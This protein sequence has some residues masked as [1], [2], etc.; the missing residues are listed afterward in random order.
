MINNK[1]H[2][3]N[4]FDEIKTYLKDTTKSHPQPGNR[5]DYNMYLSEQIDFVNENNISNDPIYLIQQFYIDKNQER[6]QEILKCLKL[7]VFNNSI[8]KIYLLNERIYD[9]NELGIQSE[10]IIQINIKE[11]LTYKDAF[12]F[13]ENNTI[14][15]N[16]HAFY[17][18]SNSD[19]FFNKSTLELK[20]MNIISNNRILALNRYD[21]KNEK[22]LTDCKL[23]DNGRPDS[24]DTWILHSSNNINSKFRDIFN[25]N[26]GKPG[27][28]NKICYL[29]NILNYKCYNEPTIIKTFHIHN[30]LSR[31]YTSVDKINKPYT[32]IFP[33]LDNF[34]ATNTNN[35]QTY[36]II[37]ENQ[38]FIK[39]LNNKITNNKQ[40]I[41]PK[42]GIN[43][44]KLAYLGILYNHN[45]KAF[46]NININ[47]NNLKIFSQ[48]Y[49]DAFHNSDIY[50]TW[51]PWS[52]KATHNNI[53]ESIVFI[54]DNFKTPTI[55]SE[56]LNVYN[57]I[58]SNNIWTQELKNKKILIIS[59][60]NN[61]IKNTI[62]NRNKIYNVELFPQCEFIFIDVPLLNNEKI[63]TLKNFNND[64]NSIVSNIKRE[65]DNF[66]IALVSCGIY[67]NLILSQISNINKSAINMD[68]S[69]QYLFGIY[70]STFENENKEISKLYKNEYWQKV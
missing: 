53:H 40:F 8:D 69:I 35:N 61:K 9:N 43:D 34:L 54:Y 17:I 22:L 62:N 25:F 41:I 45:K 3:L 16:T 32:T 6:Q 58:Q 20:K 27:C 19:I 33:V 5:I 13:I 7:N 46:D 21:Y 12:D 50:L 2:I 52:I 47:T 44:N 15:N 28:D 30:V 64:F 59:Q 57:L 29:F 48:L 10:K 49:L 63:N 31:N 36:N 67:S 51:E 24:Q 4:Y 37:N 39:Y 11:R 65:I 70:D 68:E 66:D 56:S 55:W 26:L 14:T 1:S 23:F 42:I 60:F 18:I 38:R